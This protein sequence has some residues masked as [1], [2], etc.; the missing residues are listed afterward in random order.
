MS[1]VKIMFYFSIL[2]F[3]NGK[4]NPI[5]TFKRSKFKILNVYQK[6]REKEINKFCNLYIKLIFKLICSKIIFRIR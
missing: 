2:I 6:R 3:I 4:V 1:S 5:H